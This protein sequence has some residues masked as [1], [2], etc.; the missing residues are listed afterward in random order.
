MYFRL[1]AAMSAPTK[2]GTFGENLGLAAGQMAEYSKT[3]RESEA[4]KNQLRLEIQKYKVALAHDDYAAALAAKKNIDAITWEQ[5]KFEQTV[6]NQQR[7]FDQEERKLEE[8]VRKNKAEE[9][10]KQESRGT[11]GL[12]LK[13]KQNRDQKFPKATLTLSSYYRDANEL[14]KDIKTLRNHPGLENITGFWAGRD[15]APQVTEDG[16]E[17]LRLYEKIVAKAGFNALQKMRD[18]SPTGG[19]LGNVS[20]AEGNWLRQSAGALGRVQSAKSLQK[21]LDEMESGL[22]GSVGLVQDAY[23][24]T[25]DYKDP[26]VLATAKEKM[27]LGEPSASAPAQTIALPKTV[28]MAD[29]QATATASKKSVAEVLSAFKSKGIT[30]TR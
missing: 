27:R 14:I 29:V 30:V 1:A 28:N 11:E 18:A 22:R 4:N 5:K 12:S 25:Y 19:A 20:N 21:A 23:D 10:Y 9:L 17:A 7:S 3:M 2:T 8:S 13:D 16:Q 26:D 6:S 15:W 24:M